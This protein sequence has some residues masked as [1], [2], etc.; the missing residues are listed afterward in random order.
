ML[1]DADLNGV[2][3][4]LSNAFTPQF[5]SRDGEG[6]IYSRDLHLIYTTGLYNFIDG[7]TV[8]SDTGKQY[9]EELSKVTFKVC[10]MKIKHGWHSGIQFV[11]KTSISDEL[12]KISFDERRYTLVLESATVENVAICCHLDKVLEEI[13]KF[14]DK[15]VTIRRL[16]K[17][18]AGKSAI[19]SL[20]AYPRE[21]R[22]N[23]NSHRSGLIFLLSK[24]FKIDIPMKTYI[25]TLQEISAAVQMEANKTINLDGSRFFRTGEINTI[26]CYTKISLLKQTQNNSEYESMWKGSYLDKNK[27][28]M[29]SM[30]LGVATWKDGVMTLNGNMEQ[31][32]DQSFENFK[33]EFCEYFS[34]GK[35]VVSE[36][37][38]RYLQLSVSYI[39]FKPDN[40]HDYNFQIEF[41]NSGT[42][43][44]LF[45]LFMMFG[46][47]S[48]LTTSLC[49]SLSLDM[50]TEMTSKFL[51]KPAGQ[52]GTLRPVLTLLSEQLEANAEE[53]L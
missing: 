41:T 53:V 48:T 45:N 8:L 16:L 43:T 47:V 12:R 29:E 52:N 30:R 4:E 46:L 9:F 27:L 26:P 5:I 2:S 37:S 39:S 40:E 7:K 17:S 1:T 44:N 31:L 18:A 24:F 6:T 32:V 13:Y 14:L 3:L 15:P 38:L 21:D 34:N 36:Y 51:S 20:M 28:E 33:N 35:W 11:I 25:C 10:S 19:D 49:K 50:I 23:A 42:Q 22:Y